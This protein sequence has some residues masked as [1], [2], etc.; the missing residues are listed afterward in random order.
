MHSQDSPAST[1]MCRAVELSLSVDNVLESRRSGLLSDAKI[2][3]ILSDLVDRNEDLILREQ[4]S[5]ELKDTIR[6]VRVLL[7]PF[8]KRKFA[9]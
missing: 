2:A 4:Q 9:Y 6:A 3:E 7:L 5:Q 8:S 1:L